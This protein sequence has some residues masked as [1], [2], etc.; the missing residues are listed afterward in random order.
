MREH[1]GNR[2]RHR[3]AGIAVKHFP[4]VIELFCG[5]IGRVGCAL[6][7]LRLLRLL[8]VIASGASRLRRNRGLRGFRLNIGNSSSAI[9]FISGICC[10]GFRP[11]ISSSDLNGHGSNIVGN[12]FP[13]YVIG[14][15]C[16]RFLL[17]VRQDVGDNDFASIIA[18]IGFGRLRRRF[19][20]CDVL[21]GVRRLELQRKLLF[22]FCIFENRLLR[23]FANGL[24]RRQLRNC[25][26]AGILGKTDAADASL[27]LASLAKTQNGNSQLSWLFP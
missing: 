23:I 25:S 11:G 14:I 9:C 16:C 6:F 21:R 26:D 1:S 17:A 24:T 2:V 5:R 10:G 3:R 15:H 4:Q 18:E 19:L 20:G 22:L 13:G 8:R 27:E 12:D 7:R